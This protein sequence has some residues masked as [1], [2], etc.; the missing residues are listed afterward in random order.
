MYKSL[1]VIVLCTAF[2]IAAEADPVTVSF[3]T[4]GA[5]PLNFQADT[6]SLM[7]QAGFLTLDT[8]SS[9][10][11]NINTAVFFTGDSGSFSGTQTLFL[12]YGLTIDGIT[13]DLTQ[14]AMWTITPSLD[15]FITVSPSSPVRFDTPSGTWN[16]S[17]GAYSFSAVVSD[18]GVT[19]TMPT[20]ADFKVPEPGAMKL[21]SASLLMVGALLKKRAC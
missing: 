10:T 15:T 3:S 18:I 7:G 16:V 9:T 11:A 17:L 6:F 1:M 13:Q 5:G 19:Q 8:A 14:M 2:S 21:L 20:P 12:T 4:S